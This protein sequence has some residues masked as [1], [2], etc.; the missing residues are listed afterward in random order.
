MIA[1]LRGVGVS[2]ARLRLKPPVRGRDAHATMVVL[3]ILV[4]SG[5]ARASTPVTVT[6][7]TTQPGAKISDTFAGLSFETGLMLPNARGHRYFRPDNQALIAMFRQLGVRSLRIG[8]N[9]ADRATVPIPSQEDIDSLFQFAHAADVKVLYTLRLKDHPDPS[10]AAKVAKYIWSEYRDNVECF[11][12]GNEPN[13]YIKDP[14]DYCD[15]ARKYMDAIDSPDV[16]PGAKFSG[17]G[18]TPGKVAWSRE[19]AETLGPTGKL[20]LVTQHSY[21]GGSAQKVAEATTG[22]AAMLSEKWNT[23][24]QKFYDTFVPAVQKFHVGYRLEESNSYFYGGRV[25]V[26]DTFAAALWALDFMHWWAEHECDGINFHTGDSVDANGKMS[27]SRYAV[28][29]TSEKGYHPHPL[30]YGMKTFNLSSRGTY[31]GATVKSDTNVDLTAYAVEGEDHAICIT[32]IN[33]EC[34]DGARD[35]TVAL[36]SD[37]KFANVQSMSLCAPGNDLSIKEGI[38]LGGSEIRDDATFD[39]KWS[40]LPTAGGNLKIDVPAGSAIVVKLNE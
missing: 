12:I 14:A 33:K 22:R 1:Y 38:T 32:L 26:S 37:K 11:A 27:A 17:P 10:D 5:L 31:V 39:G 20:A 13:M 9:T 25:D 7:A 40:D 29:W 3:A 16:A 30:A 2:P 28:F 35:A 8:G 34:G 21:P 15:V 6:I 24:Y 19:L 36:A 18:S 23:G 4:C